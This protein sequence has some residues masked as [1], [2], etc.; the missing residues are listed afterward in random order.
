MAAV[1]AQAEMEM[2]QIPLH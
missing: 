2:K 1:E